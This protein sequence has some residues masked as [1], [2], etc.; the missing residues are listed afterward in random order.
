MG[1]IDLNYAPYQLSGWGLGS[2]S[3]VV[4]AFNHVFST[5]T[6]GD[7]WI[8]PSFRILGLCATYWAH[9][10]S[11]RIV[12][13][14]SESPSPLNSSLGLTEGKHYQKITVPILRLVLQNFALPGCFPYNLFYCT[15]FSLLS[16]GLLLHYVALFQSRELVRGYCYCKLM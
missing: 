9:F 15:L 4:V 5:K 10:M 1:P 6:T 7:V 13:N 12:A 16:P 3:K 8:I 2:F 11:S 14:I